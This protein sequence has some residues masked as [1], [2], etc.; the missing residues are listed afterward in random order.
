MASWHVQS[1]EVQEV[2]AKMQHTHSVNYLKA[3]NIY[4]K[5]LWPCHYRKYLQEVLFQVHFTLKH[6]SITG[7][8]KTPCDTYAADMFSM[9]ILVPP[10]TSGP[11]TPKKC[12]FFQED[13]LTPDI[14]PKKFKAFTALT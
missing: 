7:K 10:P 3:Y 11:V 12:K 4:G 13:P 5:L 8:K 9:H 2:L 6:W 1:D 14:S